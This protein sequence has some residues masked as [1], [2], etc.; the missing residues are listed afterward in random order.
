MARNLLYYYNRIQR[1][2]GMTCLCPWPLQAQ[3]LMW[4][5]T[6][7]GPLWQDIMKFYKEGRFIPVGGTWVEMVGV[8]FFCMWNVPMLFNNELKNCYSYNY[9]IRY[10]F[11]FTKSSDTF[12]WSWLSCKSLVSLQLKLIITKTVRIF[13]D[14]YYEFTIRLPLF[15][16]NAF[17]TLMNCCYYGQPGRTYTRGRSLYSPVLLWAEIL[18]RIL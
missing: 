12:K 18:P 4:M 10:N 5:Y 13:I 3:Q 15:L 17:L 16:S 14:I 2:L 1:V 6:G 8:V 9:V 11:S 7:S